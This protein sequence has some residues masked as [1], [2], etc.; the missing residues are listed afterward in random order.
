MFGISDMAPRIVVETMRDSGQKDRMLLTHGR[1]R[2]GVV[3]EGKEKQN[4][5]GQCW[6]V[7]SEARQRKSRIPARSFENAAPVI[8]YDSHYRY[9]R[10]VGL[11]DNLP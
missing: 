4:E 6:Y 10:V 9:T 2:V 3:T 8:I 5:N 11:R 7:Q 1:G